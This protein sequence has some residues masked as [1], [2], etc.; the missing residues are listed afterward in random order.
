MLCWL[1]LQGSAMNYLLAAGPAPLLLS[2]L[3]RTY[4]F[5]ELGH[6]VT[7][8]IC[9]VCRSGSQPGVILLPPPRG[10]TE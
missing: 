10:D 8:V 3:E 6:W 9:G 1:V 2:F 4:L 7:Y 5:S